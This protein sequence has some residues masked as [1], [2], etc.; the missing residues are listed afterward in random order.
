MADP[1]RIGKAAGILAVSTQTLR[2]WSN[3]YVDKLSGLRLPSKKSAAGD[4]AFTEF[5]MMFFQSLIDEKSG[6]HCTGRK[7]GSKFKR[8]HANIHNAFWKKQKTDISK[9]DPVISSE[10]KTLVV[11]EEM[12]KEIVE[13]WKQQKMGTFVSTGDH[14]KISTPVFVKPKFPLRMK[15]KTIDKPLTEKIVNVPS[16]RRQ[17]GFWCRKCEGL[18]SQSIKT[19]DCVFHIAK[20]SQIEVFK[21]QFWVPAYIDIMKPKIGNM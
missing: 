4:R 1:I 21:K 15:T 14:D 18:I 9:I 19:C 13:D 20:E 17:V 5:D 6:A 3:Q 12:P 8:G 10:T 2:N 7:L 16:I 11:V